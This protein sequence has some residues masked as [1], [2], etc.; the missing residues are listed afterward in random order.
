[1][2]FDHDQVRSLVAQNE[3]MRRQADESERRIR[4]AAE[5]EIARIDSRLASRRGA[6]MSDEMA[7]HEYQTMIMRRGQL[8][9]LLA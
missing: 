6:S 3:A 2:S 1:M 5:L 9:N 4:L 7:A 8:L